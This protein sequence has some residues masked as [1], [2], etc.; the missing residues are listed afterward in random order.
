M[1]LYYVMTGETFDQESRRNAPGSR[2]CRV[3]NART[4]VDLAK[5][6][7]E[8]NPVALRACKELQAVQEHGLPAA[9]DIW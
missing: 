3:H 8:K 7:M 9:E 6:L 4:V 2:S 1:R 5:V